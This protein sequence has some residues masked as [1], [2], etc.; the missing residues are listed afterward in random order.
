M[1]RFPNVAV[2]KFSISHPLALAVTTEAWKCVASF[3]NKGANAFQTEDMDYNIFHCLVGVA[4]FQ[5]ENEHRVISSY[6]RLCKMLHGDAVVELLKMEDQNGLRPLELAASQ[7]TFKLMTSFWETPGIYLMK[8]EMI[9]VSIY[10]WIDISEYENDINSFGTGR[11]LESPLAILATIGQ[12]Q[13]DTSAGSKLFKTGIMAEWMQRSLRSKRR[14]V[15]AW[16]P[17]RLVYIATFFFYQFSQKAILQNYQIN[18]TNVTLDCATM[19]AEDYPEIVTQLIEMW[20]ILGAV[21]VIVYDFNALVRNLKTVRKYKFLSLN[22]FGRSKE[23]LIDLY[24]LLQRVS[25]LGLAIAVLVEI[26]IYKNV[27]DLDTARTFLSWLQV[28][29]PTLVSSSIIHWLCVFQAPV[30]YRSTSG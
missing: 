20:L 17:V 28:M 14:I 19:A 23:M 8:E 5:S 16:L 22:L 4:F 21:C 18:Q 2:T 25:F 26:S 29:E 10:Q 27:Y 9:G 24:T 3:W 11:T 12:S 15:M 7:G 1:K 6:K 13:Y 30:T